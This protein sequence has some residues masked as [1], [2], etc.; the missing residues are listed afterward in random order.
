MKVSIRKIIL[1]AAVVLL[2]ALAA[3]VII[4]GI[5]I[6]KIQVLGITKIND[7]DKQIDSKNKEL[8][9][10]ASTTYNSKVLTLEQTAK[11]LQNKKE[12]YENE[13]VL[14]MSSGGTGYLTTTEKYEIEFLWTKLGNYAG[15]EGIDIKMDVVNSSTAGRYDLN[16]TATGSYVGVTD[17]LYD[18]ENDSELGFKIENF[19]M[20]SSG[21]NNVQATFSCKQI[22]INIKNIDT[23]QSSQTDENGTSEETTNTN[24]TGN[25]TTNSTTTNTTTNSTK[26]NNTTTGSNTTNTTNTTTPR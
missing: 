11:S 17:Y 3:I 26:S 20:Q 1:I 25:T 16:F 2:L 14:V 24:S 15:D 19:A 12:E 8:A 18:I 6:G 13:A 5:N 22:N 4:N 21:D 23:T 7:K 10:D 9:T